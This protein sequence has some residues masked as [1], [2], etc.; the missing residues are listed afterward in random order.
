M[1]SINTNLAIVTAI[2]EQHTSVS[3]AARKFGRSRQWIYT[4]LARYNTDGVDGLHPKPTTPRTN[5]TRVPDSL[6]TEIVAIRKTLTTSGADNGPETIAWMLRQKGLRAPAESTIRRILKQQGLVQPAPKK[7]PKTSFI[8]FQAAL[9]NETWQSDITTVA[10]AERRTAE[11]LSFL[12]DHSRYLLACVAFRRV[13][14]PTVVRTFQDTIAIYGMPQSTLTDNGTVFTTRLT[15]KKGGINGF[16][17]F[18]ADNNIVQKN[19]SPSHPQTQG[20]IERFHQTL[21]KWYR[22]RELAKTIPELQK[23]LDEFRHWYNHDRPHRAVGRRTPHQAYIALP[24]A[25]PQHL[26]T[27]DARIRNDRVDQAGRITL[28]FAGVMR[29]LGI[30]RA[31]TGTRTLTVITG[32]H[33][34]TTNAD[35]SEVIAEHYIDTA[36]RYQPNQL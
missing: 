35:T 34:I 32:N 9:P 7:R 1:S 30:G 29:Y 3:E 20:K 16:E 21:K 13:Y 23:Q 6:I 10:L 18:L 8:R 19:G 25:T 15:N 14:G 11:I 31:H 33:A 2:T 4:L 28:R 22:A 5:P 17:K 12:D 27:D 36:R 24:K 26:V